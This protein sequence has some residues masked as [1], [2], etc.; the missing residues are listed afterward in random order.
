MRQLAC[1]IK[2]GNCVSHVTQLVEI[3]GL[4]IVVKTWNEQRIIRGIYIYG[5]LYCKIVWSLL[6]ELNAK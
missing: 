2:H 5:I 3:F 1:K 4:D 6:F